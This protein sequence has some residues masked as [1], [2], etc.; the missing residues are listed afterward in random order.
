MER[1]EYAVSQYEEKP[2]KKMNDEITLA[3][4]EALVSKELE[5]HLILNSSRLRTFEG[6]RREVVTYVEKQF[7]F[8]LKKKNS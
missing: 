4:L 2:K 5:K 6:A 8:F 7:G 3:G 1:W